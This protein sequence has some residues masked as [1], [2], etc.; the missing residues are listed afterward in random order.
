MRTVA[1]HYSAFPIAH[2][3][4]LIRMDISLFLYIYIICFNLNDDCACGYA[5]SH[6]R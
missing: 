1:H 5:P 4:I 6:P 2:S 3:D